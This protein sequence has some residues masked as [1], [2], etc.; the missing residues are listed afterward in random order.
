MYSRHNSPPYPEGISNYCI[1]AAWQVLCCSELRAQRFWPGPQ[2]AINDK[3]SFYLIG[4][5]MTNS[6]M[7]FAC[8]DRTAV[9]I[10][11]QLQRNKIDLS[12][13]QNFLLSRNEEP[14]RICFL[15]LKFVFSPKLARF[16][17]AP[18]TMISV[19]CSPSSSKIPF[20][21]GL[22]LC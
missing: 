8:Y 7:F 12:V 10:V 14:F 2:P 22:F 9:F 16:M 17:S 15:M 6:A 1:A 20:T 13:F 18:Q 4:F 11:T 3:K 19:H 5:L 21:E